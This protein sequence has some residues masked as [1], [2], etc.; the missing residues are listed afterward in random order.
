[1]FKSYEE[2]S[3]GSIASDEFWN[4]LFNGT[5][6]YLMKRFTRKANRA[7]RG[8]CTEDVSSEVVKSIWN[9]LRKG[10]CEDLAVLDERAGEVHV[11]SWSGLIA[12]L[13]KSAHN[14]YQSKIVRPNRKRKPDVQQ[15]SLE[16][17][18]WLDV[19]HSGK[20]SSM[21][22]IA[23]D[24]VTRIV[25]FAIRKCG[26]RDARIISD[27]LNGHDRAEIA[28][29]LNVSLATISRAFQ[30][31]TDAIAE[32]FRGESETCDRILTELAI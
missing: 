17:D 25:D 3:S 10:K 27:Y 18:E 16:N 14:K 22:F 11:K 28:E 26:S 31:L 9:A 20:H 4:E 32:E 7:T 24:F 1:M 13:K 12:Y 21:D 2:T 8:V 23:E 5:N 30:K 19:L 15:C 6:A 29:E